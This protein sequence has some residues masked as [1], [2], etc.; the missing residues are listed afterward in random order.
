MHTIINLSTIAVAD[1]NECNDTSNNKCDHICTNTNGSYEC[2]C[3]TGYELDKTNNVSCIGKN[4][5][6]VKIKHLCTI[7]FTSIVLN[8]SVY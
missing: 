4:Y 6:F 1:F 3:R 8:M 7:V 5:H 2:S